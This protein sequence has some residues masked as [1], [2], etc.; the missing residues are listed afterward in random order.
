MRDQRGFA[1]VDRRHEQPVSPGAGH[2]SRNREH[3]ADPADRPIQTE[4]S[5]DDKITQRTGVELTCRRQKRQCDG[6]I[7]RGANLLRVRR[8]AMNNTKNSDVSSDG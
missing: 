4:F 8:A 6:E 7:E 2:V 5:N 3:A 1:D